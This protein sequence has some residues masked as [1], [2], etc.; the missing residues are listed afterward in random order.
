MFRSKPIPKYLFDEL[1]QNRARVFRYKA[2]QDPADLANS[3]CG[4]MQM[5][6]PRSQ[7][8]S[9]PYTYASFDSAEVQKALS[10]L[11]MDACQVRVTSSSAL[12][13]LEWKEKE[14]WYGTEYVVAPLTQE[15]FKVSAVNISAPV[16]KLTICTSPTSHRPSSAFRHQI[17]IFHQTW[18]WLANVT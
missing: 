9:T 3:I 17:H 10:Y 5:P 11:S 4:A 8:L 1:K 14:R 18:S 6:W 15:W 16:D 13:G 7:L 12:P 2:S